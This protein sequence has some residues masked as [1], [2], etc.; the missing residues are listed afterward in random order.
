M[1]IQQK[2]HVHRDP[3]AAGLAIAGF[4]KL[5]KTSPDLAPIESL[6][7]QIDSLQVQLQVLKFEVRLAKT[8]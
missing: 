6:L 8:G 4:V 7:R 5:Q 1:T 3:A 2:P